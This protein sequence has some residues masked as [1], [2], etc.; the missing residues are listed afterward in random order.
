[1]PTKLRPKPE[2]RGVFVSRQFLRSLFLSFVFLL[3]AES[4]EL[5]PE[6]RDWLDKHPVIRYSA[7][8]GWPPFSI[9]SRDQ[10]VGIDRSLFDLFE[11][12]LGI[13][14]EYVPTNQWSENIEKLSRGE[15]DL[16]S[17]VADLPERDLGL[18][19]TRPY[20]SFPVAMIMHEDGPFYSSLE[21]VEREGL[22]LAGPKGYAPT[23]YIEKNFPN[24]PLILTK[25]S[26][27][28][29][30]LVSKG[31]ADATVENLG[32][33]SHLIRVNGLTN[34]KITGPTAHQFDPTIGVRHDLPQLHL[35][36]DKTLAAITPQE[37]Y[38][39]YKDWVLVEISGFWDAR[40]V[41]ATCLVVLSIALI[42]IGSI[43][44]W[45]R[46]LGKELAKRRAIEASLR[47]S[48]ERFRHLFETMTDACFVTQLD[49][50][51][52]LSNGAAAALLRIG[53][54]PAIGRLNLTT[55]LKEPG[56]F[57]ALLDRLRSHERLRDHP[58]DISDADG[59]I[60]PC[61][62]QIRLVKDVSGSETGIEW[63]AH[64]CENA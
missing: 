42:I 30:S 21:Q 58:L 43:A 36:L 51:I 61:L 64:P 41:M 4:S 50:L 27:E 53:S 12:R 40:R 49:G 19:Y 16:V 8:P 62:C 24:V 55:F 3:P 57:S 5:G 29:L 1:M 18:L 32:V 6:E 46:R 2:N 23:V 44:F 17:G 60:H 35:I 9:R 52:Q 7:D 14:F 56:Q 59:T 31:D 22:V 34:L 10:L 48:E 54:R 13:R 38:Q 11:K 39:I 63:I 33:A 26:L 28:S 47:E 45:N 15:I 20:A 25:T 37:R